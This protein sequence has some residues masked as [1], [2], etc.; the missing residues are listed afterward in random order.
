MMFLVW[1]CGNIILNF[2]PNFYEPSLKSQLI[3]YFYVL[4]FSISSIILGYV[5][6]GKNIIIKKSFDSVDFQSLK[7]ISILLFLG[8]IFYVSRYINLIL[9]YDTITEYLFRVRYASI[10]LGEPLLITSP[11]VTQ[12]KTFSSILSV[13]LIYEFYQNKYSKIFTLFT[14]SFIILVLLSNVIEGSRNEFVF[15]SIAYLSVFALNNNIRNMVVALSIFLSLFFILSILT[16]GSNF[17]DNLL[18]DY[19]KHLSVY[20]FGTLISFESFLNQNIAVSSSII[21]KLNNYIHQIIDIFFISPYTLLTQ[22]SAE[23]TNIS[24]NDRINVYSFL[25]VRIFYLGHFGAIVSIVVHSF[26]ITFFYKKSHNIFFIYIYIFMIPSTLLSLF[27]E[28]FFAMLPYYLRF[29]FVII[30]L[31]KLNIRK[32]IKNFFILIIKN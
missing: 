21:V 3:I 32:L 9:S 24:N 22:S 16:R 14:I 4:I 20:S 2:F 11:L 31:Y 13:I 28:Y 26:L 6:N 23:F 29:A 15:L 19:I 12:I 1:T 5:I 10:H 27:H 30:F 17:H 18:F 25:S 8:L 7:I